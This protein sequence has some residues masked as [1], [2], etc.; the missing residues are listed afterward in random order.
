MKKPISHR[1]Q[2]RHSDSSPLS[3][4]ARGFIRGMAGMFD[5]FGTRATSRKR[6][7]P[8]DDARNLH[9]D[10]QRIGDDFRAVFSKIR[11]AQPK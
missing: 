5:I 4:F 2:H 8:Q 7:S 10:V 6:R 11:A 1:H 9:R 3:P